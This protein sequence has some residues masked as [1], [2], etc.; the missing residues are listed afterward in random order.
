MCEWE[1]YIDIVCVCVCVCVCVYGV[2]TGSLAE[3]EQ[4]AGARMKLCAFAYV[5]ARV[6]CMCVH[7]GCLF[8]CVYVRV[9]VC[10]EHKHVPAIFICG[11]RNI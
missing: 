3:H 5:C 4:I 1:K 10:V 11:A 9:Y 7:V 2:C 6:V 8:A